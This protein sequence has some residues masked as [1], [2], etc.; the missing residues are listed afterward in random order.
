M[1]RPGEPA[2][3]EQGS[4]IPIPGSDPLAYETIGLL[5]EAVYREDPP[6]IATAAEVEGHLGRLVRVTGTVARAKLG[7]QVQAAEFAVTCPDLRVPDALL[8]R[9]ATV[10]GTLER[11]ADFAATVGPDGAIGQG[12]EPGTEILVLHGCALR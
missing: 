10:E 7:D 4:R 6:E 1:T 3:L 11:R 5:F 9:E 8:G 2:R 12:T